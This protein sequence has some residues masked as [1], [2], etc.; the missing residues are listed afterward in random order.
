MRSRMLLVLVA[1]VALAAPLSAHHGRG[2][3]FDEPSGDKTGKTR[4][5]NCFGEIHKLGKL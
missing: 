4:Q 3:S 5:E 1:A 2:K